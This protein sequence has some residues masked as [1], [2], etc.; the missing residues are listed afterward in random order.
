MKRTLFA[1]LFFAVAG[2]LVYANRTAADRNWS[3][4]APLGKF[5]YVESRR[6]HFPPENAEPVLIRNRAVLL[7][8]ARFHLGDTA[9]YVLG[10]AFAAS[11]ILLWFTRQSKGPTVN[12]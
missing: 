10:A 2:Y 9:L 11:G 8:P 12:Y 4:E 7:G 5:G 6:W 1:I 3:L